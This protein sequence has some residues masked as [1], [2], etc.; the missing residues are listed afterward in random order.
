MTGDPGEE[1]DMTDPI[2]GIYDSDPDNLAR[3]LKLEE[4][5]RDE[6][7]TDEVEQILEHQLQAPLA[8]EIGRIY[9]EKQDQVRDQGR[10]Q[11]PPIETVGDLLR[12]D[13]PPEDLLDM[14]KDGAKAARRDTTESLPVEVPTAIYFASI[15]AALVKNDERISSLSSEEM[16]KGFD[17]ASGQDWFGKQL[18]DLLQ[19]ATRKL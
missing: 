9:P 10:A 2:N 1:E 15:A 13:A 7:G 18:K 4:G 12:H 11:E 6:W 3:L 17:W 19:E 14:L 8:D 5:R 16:K